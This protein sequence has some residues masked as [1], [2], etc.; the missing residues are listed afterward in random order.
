[1][2]TL[3]QA[4]RRKVIKFKTP[5]AEAVARLRREALSK[6]DFDPA[7]LFVWGYMMGLGLL[8][9]LRAVEDRFGQEGQQVA[10]Q[11]LV[12]LGE[13]V[14]E[15]GLKGVRIPKDLSDVEKV[16]L[17]CTWIN[18]VPYAS[19]EKPKID[20]PEQCSFDIL[21]CPHED[22]Y[23]A[24][25]CRIQRYIV[26]GMIRATSKR[27]GM[28]NFQVAFE[29]TI[30]AGA[31]VCHFRLWRRKPGEPDAWTTYSHKLADRALTG[32]RSP[33]AQRQ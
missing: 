14:A 5:F 10:T 22:M 19:V 15:E 18:E 33:Q 25:D 1:M 8:E 26:E 21:W 2:K 11:A 28:G 31:P 16:S 9:M 13:R 17:F 3:T 24:F 29:T 27:L 6:P 20:S 7:N 4:Q 32:P 30:P 23:N 12:R